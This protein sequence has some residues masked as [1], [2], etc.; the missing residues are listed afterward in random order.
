MAPT[1]TN[2]GSNGHQPRLMSKRVGDGGG[3]PARELRLAM[4]GAETQGPRVRESY[5]TAPIIVA[6]AAVVEV[7]Q[8]AQ[9]RSGPRDRS[10]PPERRRK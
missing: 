9:E 7:L 1:D 8:G 10:G 4:I 5:I 6:V 3:P 2:H